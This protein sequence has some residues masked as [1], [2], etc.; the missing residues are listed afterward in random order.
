MSRKDK[1][2]ETESRLVDGGPGV[3]GRY[4][5][6]EEWGVIVNGYEVSLQGDENVELGE[7]SDIQSAVGL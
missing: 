4:K 6:G 2:I 5:R 1:S 3:G 7:M